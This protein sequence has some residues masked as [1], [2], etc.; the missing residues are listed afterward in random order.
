MFSAI[1]GTLATSVYV[2]IFISTRKRE[3]RE[4]KWGRVEWRHVIRAADT[5]NA[6]SRLKLLHTAL[7]ESLLKKCQLGRTHIYKPAGGVGNFSGST[8]QFPEHWANQISAPKLYKKA[9]RQTFC[10]EKYKVN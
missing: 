10:V 9:E 6:L 8:R 2:I 7:F 3:K 4:A 1:K 5:P